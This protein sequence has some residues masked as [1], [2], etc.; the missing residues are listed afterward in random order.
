M[1]IRDSYEGTLAALRVG[2]TDLAPVTC[3][4]GTD[5]TETF[6]PGAGDRYYLVAATVAGAEGALGL[7]S[8]GTPRLQAPGACAIRETASCP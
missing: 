6:V 1:C 2:V 8:A 7:T 4:A 5:L 3:V